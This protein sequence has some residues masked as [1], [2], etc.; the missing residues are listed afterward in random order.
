MGQ[1]QELVV[2]P[3]LFH[4]LAHHTPRVSG[5]V[6]QYKRGS[7]GDELTR[8]RYDVI[9]RV[10][11]TLR[12]Q[13]SSQV[14][15]WPGDVADLSV[16]AARLDTQTRQRL[17]L[18]GLPNGRVAKD[19]AIIDWLNDGSD[20]D[21]LA[22]LPGAIRSGESAARVDP[23]SI[24]QFAAEHGYRAV[25]SPSL[26]APAAA[27]DVLLDPL[28]GPDLP[29][30]VPSAILTDVEERAEV[31]W[32]QGYTNNPLH[33]RIVA[34]CVPQ[35]RDHLSAK[36][37]AYMQPS[38]FV[39]MER[40]PLNRNGKIDR[41]T[42]P[43]P[44]FDRGHLQS[45]FVPPRTSVEQVLVGMW[46]DLLG[47]EGIG[48]N[49]NFFELGG[50]SIRAMRFINE[51][52]ARIKQNIYVVAI[53]TAPTVAQFIEYIRDHYPGA[54]AALG[55]TGQPG[56]GAAEA[57]P[58]DEDLL[59]RVRSALE[60]DAGAGRMPIRSKSLRP[61]VFVLAPPRSG[62]SLLRILL[63]GHRDLFSPPELNLLNHASLRLRRDAYAGRLGF[64]SEGTVRAIM[65]A[66][67]V[68][69]TEA[70]Q[71]MAQCEEEGLS[72]MAFYARLQDWIGDRVLVDKS[73]S[74]CL[75]AN[76]LQAA[77]DGFANA[78]YLHLVRHPCATIRSFEKARTDLLLPYQLEFATRATAE[79]LWVL[80]HRNILRFLSAVPAERQSRIGFEDL[81]R[82]PRRAMERVCA[83]LRI[84]FDPDMLKPY[85]D[86]RRRMTDG[87]H[88]LSTG[89][90]DPRFQQHT[91]I[92]PAVADEWR[93][94][95]DP[96]GLRDPA[97]RLARAL[98][99]TDVPE[100]AEPEVPVSQR[101][102]TGIGEGQSS[103]SALL[104]RL[105]ELSDE[106]VRTLLAQRR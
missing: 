28:S 70:V 100:P 46:Q 102:A 66:R 87:I 92:E 54:E 39:V 103:A 95:M 5:A 30:S 90:T 75:H 98:G 17:I 88:R 18:R 79:A 58:V 43:S 41:R 101:P 26:A 20:D 51:L 82:D 74:Y 12:L 86:P 52:Q 21:T 45:E 32:P 71:I 69:A 80:G 10:N 24:W 23:E 16:L 77:E 49:D 3:A 11:E 84:E 36:L 96:D 94:E 22:A 67:N 81:L 53:F 1:E 4:A 25:V 33:A 76:A 83:V 9:V 50:D 34:M 44:V 105:D 29:V 8:Y 104:R 73:A 42:L 60:R 91:G 37:P 27:L 63:G 56:M 72:T 64:L 2:D 59:S 68:D 55:S 78:V 15:D 48:V 62:T 85:E 106:E 40:F 14:L 31:H 89:L 35:W 6:V 99:Y 65:G 38:A 57:S 97:R 13:P 47:V 7:G 19:L 61:I 93:S